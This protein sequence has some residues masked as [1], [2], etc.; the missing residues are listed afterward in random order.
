MNEGCDGGWPFFH[1]FLAENGHMVTEECAPYR[2]KTKGDHCS[3]Y[4]DCAPHSKIEKTRFV[5]KG[6][7]DTSEKKMMQEIARNGM[8]NG[9]LN[10]PHI[11]HMYTKGVLTADGIK[12]LHKKALSLAQVRS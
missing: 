12:E 3:N 4:A 2:G 11:F 10:A 7:G 6:Y 8:V 5:G 9:E 1:G